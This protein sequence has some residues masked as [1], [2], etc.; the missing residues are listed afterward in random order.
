MDV[1]KHTHEVQIAGLPL[2]LRSSHDAQTVNELIEL[3]NDRVQKALNLNP[4]ISFQKALLMAS[5]HIA[6]DLLF[7]KRTTHA[8]LDDLENKA[9]RIL[10]ELESSPIARIRLEN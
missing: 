10:S 9:K 1:N 8:E 4:H 5:L 6:E 2:K 7:L 3:V